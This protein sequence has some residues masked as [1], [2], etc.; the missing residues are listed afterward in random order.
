[1]GIFSEA[2]DV[3]LELFAKASGSDGYL[4]VVELLNRRDQETPSRDETMLTARADEAFVMLGAKPIHCETKF[5]LRQRGPKMPVRTTTAVWDQVAPENGIEQLEARLV[6]QIRIW[7]PEVVVASDVNEQSEPVRQLIQRVIL[8]AIDRAADPKY[9]VAHLA[10]IGLAPSG[11][12]A[13]LPLPVGE[14]RGEGKGLPLTP[15]D[16]PTPPTGPWQVKRTYATAP[17]SQAS[18]VTIASGQLAPRIGRLLAEATSLPRG[19]LYDEYRPAPDA[20]GFRVLQSRDPSSAAAGDLLAGI[21]LRPGGGARRNLAEPSG[22][23]LDTLRRAATQRHNLQAI[24]SHSGDSTNR[25][26]A[27]IGPLT[28]GLDE[29]SAG[30]ILF[31]LGWQSYRT[32]QWDAAAQAFELLAT[33]YP[34]HPLTSSARRWLLQYYASQVAAQRVRAAKAPNLAAV[35]PATANLPLDPRAKPNVQR[36]VMQDPSPDQALR[37]GA[38]AIAPPTQGA[39]IGEPPAKDSLAERAVQLGQQIERTD[40]ALFAEPTVRFPLAAAYRKLGMGREADHCLANLRF[41]P[42]DAWWACAEGE[43][44]LSLGRGVPPKSVWHC[45]PALKRPRLDGTLDD[46]AWKKA[47]PVQL[48]STLRDDADWAATAMLTYDQQFLYL[49]VRCHQAAGVDYPPAEGVRPRNADLA[50]RDRIDLLLCP[51]RD[52]TT[53]YRLSIDHRGW[54]STAC[55][56]DAT[57]HPALFVAAATA[58]DTWI[59]EAA[60][61]WSELAAKAPLGDRRPWGAN[62]QR[63][64]P[65]VGFQSWSQPATIE[66]RPEGFGYLE[67]E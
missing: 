16:C 39:T 44:C 31:Q 12:F 21:D 5:P 56:G 64:V 11:A 29:A 50:R 42:H 1:M 20:I 14:G 15:P 34:Q 67:F 28:T 40:P 6:R 54:V 66:I 35:L 43:N 37:N 36:A 25:W 3:P 45:T 58:D 19:V 59:I 57:W 46:E 47:Q 22:G 63:I 62:I 18:T 52:Y 38:D 9:D 51:D 53:W 26:L 55:W 24:L 4:S 32:G 27:Q 65:E 7:R 2:S 49:A 23:A 60:I 13:P 17:P 61:P 41:G 48:T 33:Q 10:A 30:E 8:D